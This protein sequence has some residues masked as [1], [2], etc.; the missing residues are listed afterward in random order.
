MTTPDEFSRKT[1]VTVGLIAWIAGVS[2]SMGVLYARINDHSK[3]IKGA[4]D[5][6]K[7]EVDGLR[8][9]W[10]MDKERQDQEI[11]RLESLVFDRLRR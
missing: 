2:F 11:K 5:Y 7:Q 3:D 10:M 8:N 1:T 6:T 9:D 4:R